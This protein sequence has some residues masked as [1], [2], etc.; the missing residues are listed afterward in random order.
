[1]NDS[2]VCSK[3]AKETSRFSPQCLFCGESLEGPQLTQN[4]ETSIPPAADQ[5]IA[6]EPGPGQF[7][8]C[9]HCAEII[10]AEAK[11]CK[12]CKTYVSE[13]CQRAPVY[14][15]V[16]ASPARKG[17]GVAIASFV[18]GI[19]AVFTGALGLG[20]L[21]AIIAICLGAGGRE[22]D[23]PSLA[24]WG[25]GLGWFVIISS[26]LVG[27]LALLFFGGALFLGMSGK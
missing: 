1:M 5:K 19:L 23:H 25:V 3:C 20:F 24:A 21:L 22:S 2:I 7:K 13:P 26:I 17:N 18:L 16:V 15:P 6:Q 10:R 9:P 4:T 14:Q 11:K 8:K 27:V 12:H